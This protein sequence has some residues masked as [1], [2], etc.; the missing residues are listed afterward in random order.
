MHRNLNSKIMVG[1]IAGVLLAF[2]L[3]GCFGDDSDDVIQT[4]ADTP[5]SAEQAAPEATAAPTAEPDP[6]AAASTMTGGECYILGDPVTD[7]PPVSPHKWQPQ[8][9]APNKYPIY[10][11]ESPVPS[12]FFE[13]PMSYQ[14]VKAGELPAVSERLPHPLDIKVVDTPEGIGVYGGTFRLTAHFLFVGEFAL[15]HWVKRDSEGIRWHPHVGKSFE[16]SEDGR[17]WTMKLRQG[18]KWSDG[19]PFEIEDVRFGWEDVAFNPE[20]NTFALE[21][22]KDPVTGNRVEFNVVDEQTW[23]LSYDTPTHGLFDGKLVRNDHCGGARG[24][25]CWFSHHEYNKQWHPKYAS[26]AALNSEIAKNEVENWV[27]LW[28]LKNNA[29]I[30]TERPC[31]Q[32]WC[33]TAESDTERTYTRNHYFFEVDPEGNQ[34]PYIDQ[35]SNFRMESR[36]V[37]VFRAMN[38]EQDGQTT[39]YLIKELPLYTSNMNQGDYS[40]YHWPSTGGNDAPI[41]LNQTYNEDPY[42]GQLIRTGDFR[43]ALSLAIDRKAINEVVYLGIGTV[44]NYAPH[45]VTPYYPGPEVASLNIH[46]DPDEANRLLDSLGLDKR[47]AEGFRLRADNGERLQL[48]SA[49]WASP[50]YPED[51]PIMEF[52]EQ[53]WVAV[54]IESTHKLDRNAANDIANNTAYMFIRVDFGRYQANPWIGDETRTVPLRAGAYQASEIGRYIESKGESGM[55]PTG[56]NPNWLPLAP[57]GTYPADASGNLKRLQDLWQEGR[58]Y[59]TFNPQRIRIG[60][61][62]FRINAEELYVIPTVAF[63]GS[64]RGIFINRN[65]VHNQPKTHELDH[66]G[67]HTETYYF[68]QGKDNLNNPGNRSQFCESWAFNQGGVQQCSQ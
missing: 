32:P 18:L 17:V 26:S 14:L 40:I 6:P 63:S 57:E 23:Q 15:G 19:K 8:A 25:L 16:V 27:Q 48:R 7:C 36:D 47:D 44:Q 13:S 4:D 12:T 29:E 66:F 46:H 41:S 28:N 30:N 54:G 64:S 42:I 35:V 20:I 22:Y 33:T 31:V 65:N 59:S 49:L 51:I 21:V 9:M 2:I 34:L 11:G 58:K 45:A 39:P 53:G 52:A 5:P 38:G 61:D 1:L 37:A 56:P 50:S 43:K 24:R 55:G 62:L 68:E 60:R 67:W 3:V 10:E